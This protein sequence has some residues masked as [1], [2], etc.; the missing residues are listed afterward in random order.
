[1]VRPLTGAAKGISKVSAS[2][3]CVRRINPIGMYG[4]MHRDVGERVGRVFG[5]DASTRP[6]GSVAV[7]SPV[8][9]SSGASNLVVLAVGCKNA[10][11]PFPSYGLGSS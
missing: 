5:A 3:R 8:A 2:P 9:G 10:V 1:M 11:K 6:W 7:A 4:L